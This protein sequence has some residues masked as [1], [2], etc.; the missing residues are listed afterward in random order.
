MSPIKYLYI[1]LSLLLILAASAH[2]ALPRTG[3]ISCYDAAGSKIACANTGQDAAILAGL[4]WPDSRFVANAGSITDT[5]TGL[6][7]AQ[8]GNIIKNNNPDFDADGISGDGKVSWEH[9][10]NFVKKLNV[11]GYLG[12]NDWRLPNI[13]ELRTLQDF[14]KTNT[15]TW[16]N[17]EGFYGIMPDRYWSGTTNPMNPVVAKGVNFAS[18]NVFADV[19]NGEKQARNN[20]LL[21]VRGIPLADSILPTNQLTCYGTGGNNGGVANCV[22]SGQDGEYRIGYD[23]ALNRYQVDNNTVIDKS[24][25]LIWPRNMDLSLSA[26]SCSQAGK[27]SWQAA[28]DFI[29]CLNG[30]NFLEHNDWKMPNANEL[31]T[32]LDHRAVHP[33]TYL[34]S[35]GFTS[36]NNDYLWTSTSL[37]AA[38]YGAWLVSLYRGD[39]AATYKSASYSVIPVREYVPLDVTSPTA[40]LTSPAPSSVLK[41]RQA[42]ISGTAADSGSGVAKVQISTD[43]GATWATAAG[44][45]AWSY[46]WQLPVDGSYTI[47][48]KVT[49]VAGNIAATAASAVVTVDHLK[50]SYPDTQFPIIWKG[51]AVTASAAIETIEFFQPLFGKERKRVNPAI[52]ATSGSSITFPLAG[53]YYL[54]INGDC[55]LKVIVL[56]PAEPIS[57]GVVRIFDF[58]VANMLYAEQDQA[59]FYGFDRNVFV[60]NWF[61]SENPARLDCGPTQVVFTILLKDRF[62]L[63]LRKV[64]FPGVFKWEGNRY[65]ATH[66]LTEVYLP[67]KAKW[68]LFDINYAFFVRWMSALELVQ[69]LRD[70]CSSYDTGYFSYV[71]FS[72]LD[73]YPDAPR[74]F[75]ARNQT[76]MTL[77]TFSP[78]QV[79]TIPTVYLWKEAFR[80]YYS[81]VAYW[82][83][84]VPWLPTGTEFLSGDVVF[85]QMHTN[86]E[87]AQ[88]AV[89][90]E[91]SYGLQVTV[92]TP[93]EL[94][95]ALAIGAQAEIDLKAWEQRIP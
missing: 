3:Q 69:Y 94:S 29:T 46:T 92:V 72:Q 18:G 34:A 56:D 83:N 37:A 16:L 67:D 54:K 76:D 65:Y 43:A 10:L 64:T 60:K 27:L 8:D 41:G 45:V 91:R 9:A 21:P 82:G 52:P 53:E 61:E 26:S 13:N 36:F 87:L 49:D 90:Y 30:V 80:F 19:A 5:M 2:A 93:S 77:K 51:Q 50:F 71:P 88:A 40:T 58:C 35:V 42:V 38:P 74:S 4:V 62:S 28:L 7:W 17:Q 22:S 39:S 48:V 1:L 55:Y 95:Q 89:D 75:M 47:V 25:K 73:V 86:P 24:A 33:A 20:F 15:A 14:E 84:N 68:V 6:S 59:L 85:A 57:A 66:N 12:H 79:S 78:D 11:A 63:P 32:L 44:T 23:G 81:G 70:N 31:A